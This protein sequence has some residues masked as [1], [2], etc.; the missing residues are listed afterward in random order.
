MEEFNLEAK[1]NFLYENFWNG[2]TEREKKKKK[3]E[4]KSPNQHFYSK[5]S[6]SIGVKSLYS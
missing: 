2:P 3:K 1:V 6:T 4:K 5:T